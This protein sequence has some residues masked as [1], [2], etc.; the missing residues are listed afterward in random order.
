MENCKTLFSAYNEYKPHTMTKIYANKPSNQAELY[1]LSIHGVALKPWSYD[2][3]EGQRSNRVYLPWLLMVV[4]VRVKLE[5]DNG[6]WFSIIPQGLKS[7]LSCSDSLAFKNKYD[8]CYE[9]PEYFLLE[10]YKKGRTHNCM[11]VRHFDLNKEI[12]NPDD[13]TL[14]AVAM[15]YRRFIKENS[16]ELPKIALASHHSYFSRQ[17]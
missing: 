10:V 6:I 7:W 17:F 12:Y 1:I 4:N 3:F 15:G 9:R 11:I 2:K 5:F 16:I 13:P 8:G 14:N